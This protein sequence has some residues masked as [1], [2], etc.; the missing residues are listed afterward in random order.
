MHFFSTNVMEDIIKMGEEA[1]KKQKLEPVNIPGQNETF[2]F[3]II[4]SGTAGSVL[5]NRLSENPLWNVLLVESGGTETIVNEI[6]V[7]AGFLQLTEAN[8]KY[9]S[10]PQK[11]ACLGVN[12]NKMFPS[13]W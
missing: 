10:T 7:L 9:Q 4:G 1:L 5:A 13:K 11:N 2:D 12:E 3:M 8:W 6:P